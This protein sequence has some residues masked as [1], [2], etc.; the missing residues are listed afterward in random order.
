MEAEST[1]K[2]NIKPMGIGLSLLFFAIPSAMATFGIYFVMQRLHH[3]SI[4]DFINLSVSMALPLALLLIAA[5]VAYKMEGR[6]FRWKEFSDRFR[7]RKMTRKDWIYTLLL[8]LAQIIIYISLSFTPRW[9]IH[10]KMFAPPEF[11]IP[12]VDPRLEQ[13]I[14]LD[15]FLGIP[16]KGQWW[17]AIFYFSVLLF[18]IF[19]EEFWWRG[20]IFPRQELYF[21]KWTWVVHGTLWGCFH[22]F[23]KWNLL[24]L[25]PSC[26]AVS[27]VIYK[28]KNTWIG[29]ITHMAFNSIPLIGIIIGIIG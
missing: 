20:Y 4:N 18:N 8:F 17:I 25:I 28:R 13:S 26:L 16:L 19:G 3:N 7:L 6:T 12:A 9:L 15:S 14:L 2:L 1:G 21:K 11:L 24:I 29:I 5:F 23:W 10:F 22:V 27:W